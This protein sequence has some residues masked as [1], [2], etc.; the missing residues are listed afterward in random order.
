MTYRG[1]SKDI[2]R[3]NIKRLAKVYGQ[4][5]TDEEIDKGLD[6]VIGEEG[7]E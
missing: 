5:L 2:I 3:K 6:E 7:K 4:K 1:M